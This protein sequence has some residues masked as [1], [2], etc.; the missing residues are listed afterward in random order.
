MLIYNLTAVTIK[1]IQ[2]VIYHKVQGWLQKK[3]TNPEMEFHFFDSILPDSTFFSSVKN[4]F[5]VDN[6]QTSQ[7][8]VL[9]FNSFADGLLK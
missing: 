3:L 1:Y 6:L 2:A 9:I 5:C 8:K 4:F 7:E